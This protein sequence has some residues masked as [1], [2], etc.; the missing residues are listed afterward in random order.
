VASPP[1]GTVTFLFTDI[2]GSTKM[3]QRDRE[4]MSEALVRH[5]RILRDAV[6]QRGG[7]VFKTV[8]DAFCCAFAT[9]PDGLEAALEAQRELFSERREEGEPLKVRMAL[10]TGAAEE[11]DGDY[12]GPPVN[13]V[14]RLLSAAHG[15]QVLLSAATQEMVRDQLPARASLRDLGEHRLKDLFR[16]ERVFQLLSTGLTTKFAPLGTLDAYRNNLPLQPTSLVGR[17]REVSEVCE[18]LSRPE[19]K[20][21]TLTGAGG[22]GKTRLALQAAAE[23]TGEFEDGVFFVSLAAISD[24]ELVVGAVAATLGVKEAGGQPL[25]ENLEEYLRERRMLLLLD[26]F[27]QVLGAAPVVG[28][29]HSGAPDLKVL[30]TSRIPLRLYGEHEY[31]V[32]PLALP[33]LTRPPSLQRLTQYEAVRLFVERAQAAKAGFSVTDENAPAVAEICHRLDGLP[34]AIE[35]AAARI[36]ILTPQAM[37]ARLGNR[38]RLLTGGARDLPERQRTLRSTIE[39]S[40]GLLDEGERVLFGRLSVFAGGRTLEAME[41]ICDSE[42]ELPG[43][44]LDDISVLVD[45]NLLRQEE[46]VGGEPRFVMLETVHEFAREKLQESGQT[47]DLRRRHA[48]YFISMAEEAEPELMRAQQAQW[49]KRLELELDNLRAA[50]SWA[51]EQDEAELGLRL[52]A[53]LWRF[54]IMGARYG[55]GRKW[56]EAALATGKEA[57]LLVRAKANLVAGYLAAGQGVYMHSQPHL[58]V[59]L[60][61]YRSAGSTEGV[62]MTLATLGI[63]ASYRGDLERAKEL[64]KESLEGYRKLGDPW[65]FSGALRALAADLFV[66]LLRFLAYGGD[67]MQAAALR[68]EA[69]ALSRKWGDSAGI[70]LSLLGLGY[71]A[72]DQ[73]N[74]ERAV[75]HLEEGLVLAREVY[76]GIVP[77]ILVSLGDAALIQGD[78]ERALRVY[79]EALAICGETGQEPTD[80]GVL[81]GMANLAAALGDE[82]RAARLWGALESALQ[83]IGASWTPDDLAQDAPY[84]DA[85]RSRLGEAAWEAALAEGKNMTLEEAIAYALEEAGAGSR[86]GETPV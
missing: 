59:A 37:L 16:P 22:T 27:E 11:R 84:L 12:F 17:E 51:E 23:V 21:L 35:L 19:L 42:G 48:R 69:L 10:H 73:D 43:S 65:Q 30:A 45:E 29:L 78:N 61:L 6:E 81:E 44:V 57:P 3:W 86:T 54:W 50:L 67:D 15:G 36:K 26:N 46:G 31:S 38:L 75:K 60:A 52:G 8:G 28:D 33:D 4:T 72:I 58:E 63:L 20:L 62:A 80:T 71:L 66:R 32:P 77:H 40:H 24:A 34:L 14:A 9:A 2:E 56:L 74:P 70:A 83:A 13:R 5:D 76:A 47:E 55:E 79:K 53:A 64:N 85:A 7:Y 82:A 68:E 25:L 49:L 41:A 39:W 1:T 18:R